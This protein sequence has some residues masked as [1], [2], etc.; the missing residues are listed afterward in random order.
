MIVSANVFNEDGTVA[1]FKVTHQATRRIETR[2]VVSGTMEGVGGHGE[3]RVIIYGG[4]RASR[5]VTSGRVLFILQLAEV[6]F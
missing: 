5:C 6:G 1:R 4:R 2:L 3:G